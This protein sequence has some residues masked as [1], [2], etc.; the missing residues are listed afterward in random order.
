MV[1][2]K[3]TIPDSFLEEEVRCGYTVSKKMKEI[4]AVQLDLFAEFDRVCQKYGIKYI[5]SGG[6]MLGAVRHHGY[7]PWDDDIDLMMMRDEYEKLCSIAP[8]EFKYP[9]FFQTEDTESGFH[10]WFARLRNS[11]TTAIQA[12]EDSMGLKYNQGIFI[13]IFPLDNVIDDTNLYQ[14][15]IKKCSKYFKLYNFLHMI[16]FAVVEKSDS[17][18]KKNIRKMLQ[19][20]FSKMIREL[21]LIRKVYDKLDKTYQQ[22]NNVETEYVSLVSFQIRNL[23]HAIRKKDMTEI[24]Y[25]NFEFLKIPI[26]ANYDEHL[27]R[28]YG[29]Y[30]TPLNNPN[31]HGDIFFDTDHSYL[32]YI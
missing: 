13:D 5:A 19:L 27:R 14:R 22:Y 26:I 20:L 1:D 30:M 28:K 18:I 29:D 24:I 21:R 2:L 16:E 10:R 11:E 4:W 32:R 3:L 23:G 15:Q 6:T 12:K 31:Y 7:I 17:Y 9:Y 25:T 8:Q